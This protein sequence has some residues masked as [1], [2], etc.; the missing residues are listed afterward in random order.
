MS[1]NHIKSQTDSKI[2]QQFNITKEPDWISGILNAINKWGEL[3]SILSE[4]L[5][6]S[7]KR[8]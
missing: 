5:K 7:K 3:K 6:N 8:Q 4:I 1:S 2:H